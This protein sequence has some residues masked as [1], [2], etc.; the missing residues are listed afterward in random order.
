MTWSLVGENIFSRARGRKI[1]EREGS[2]GLYQAGGVLEGG[3][4]PTSIEPVAQLLP[5]PQR[6][7]LVPRDE[8]AALN[9]ATRHFDAELC[10]VAQHGKG[11]IHAGMVLYPTGRPWRSRR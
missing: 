4:K 3:A 7:E 2:G 9:H 1:G 8:I 11:P 5:R 6:R 10:V